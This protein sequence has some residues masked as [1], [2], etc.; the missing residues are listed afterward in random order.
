MAIRS[1]SK[2][3][4]DRIAGLAVSRH[5]VSLQWTRSEGHLPVSRDTSPS[6]AA[7]T[8]G[9]QATHSVDHSSA[10]TTSTEGTGLQRAA[11][12]GW[13][14]GSAPIS[15]DPN[16]CPRG[17]ATPAHYARVT[18][19]CVT[20]NSIN[21]VLIEASPVEQIHSPMALRQLPVEFGKQVAI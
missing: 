5:I 17:H 3:L 8:A 11:W 16:V 15:L 7:T 12:L 9:K 13:V 20:V 2:I 21:N 19:S 6:K 14:R 1:L 4:C 18:A 10:G